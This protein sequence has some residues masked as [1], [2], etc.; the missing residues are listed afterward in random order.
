MILQI[1]I[2]LINSILF[3]TYLV[4]II[5]RQIQSIKMTENIA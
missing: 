1:L 4:N 5:G 2:L 3:I